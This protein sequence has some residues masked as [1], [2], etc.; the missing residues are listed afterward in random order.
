MFEKLIE[1]VFPPVCSFCGKIDKNYFCPKCKEKIE[2]QEILSIDN[3]ENKYFEKHISI[4]TYE[5]VI[6]EE[7]LEYKFKRKVI[8]I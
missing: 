7:I 6:R 4:F 1:I 2:L 5:G 8:C 3:I